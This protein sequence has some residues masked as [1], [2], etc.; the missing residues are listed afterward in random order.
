MLAVERDVAL[1]GEHDRLV[2]PVTLVASQ[3]DDV[4]ALRVQPG[5]PGYNENA[6]KVQD[7]DL[8]GDVDPKHADSRIDILKQMEDDFAKSRLRSGDERPPA[9][10][11]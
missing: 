1:T 10:A 4:P 11:P 6:L 2:G 8:P 5:Q 7:L 9:S 3:L